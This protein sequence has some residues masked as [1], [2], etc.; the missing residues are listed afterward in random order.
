MSMYYL[1]WD[2]DISWLRGWIHRWCRGGIYCWVD[3]YEVCVLFRGFWLVFWW[4]WCSRID[5][6]EYS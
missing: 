2:L 6:W 5:I 3:W 4:D 1:C